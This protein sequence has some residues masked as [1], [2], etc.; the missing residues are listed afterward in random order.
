MAQA[1]SAP[2]APG[3]GGD[4]PHAIESRVRAELRRGDVAAATALTVS[5]FGPEVHGFLIAVLAGDRGAPELY[6]R[7]VAELRRQLAG[8]GWRCPL[9]VFVYFVAR[10]ALRHH[11]GAAPLG[12]PLSSAGLAPIPAQRRARRLAVAL[13]RR[14]L[15]PD[16]R[17]LLVLRVDRRLAWRDLA[18][19]S[20]G[21]N[22]GVPDL[23]AE[24]R[25]LR[26][27]FK[28]LRQ[29]MKQLTER[30]AA[31]PAKGE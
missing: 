25:R 20:L 5:F 15:T 28:V 9:R 21:E 7:F 16:D 4:P 17:A 18:I 2:S 27:R 26:D 1:P 29:Q 13:L 12:S 6:A 24:A 3:P 11:R 8:F 19:T 22:V 30:P 10:S 23:A 31:S 14:S